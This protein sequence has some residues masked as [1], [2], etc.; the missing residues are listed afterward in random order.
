MGDVWKAR[1]TE[2][3][4]M[5][6]IKLLRTELQSNPD[7][8]ERFEREPQLIA[9]LRHP[10]IVKIHD[11]QVLPVPEEDEIITYMV[12]DFVEGQTLADYIRSTSRKGKFPPAAD[13][14]YIFSAISR[15]LDYAHDRGMIH[16]DI[17]PANILLDQRTAS[18]KPMGEP[19]LTDFGI[20]R[21][22][23]FTT[24][25]VA[26]ALLGT[27][28]YIAP[29]Q[30]KGQS[31]DKRSDLYSLGVILYEMMTG[32]TPFR[33]DTTIAIL[34]QHIHDMPT[35]PSLINPN[36]P[37]ALNMVILKSISKDPADRYQ[38][39]T[40]MTIALAD[41]LNVP[42]PKNLLPTRT[43]TYTPLSASPLTPPD[44]RMNM[45]TAN[46]HQSMMIPPAYAPT[47]S[48]TPPLPLAQTREILPAST[49]I[50]P[51]A[52]QPMPIPTPVQTPKEQQ[53]GSG[54]R[55]M[56][57]GIALG[58]ILLLIV[59]IAAAT[60][61]THK[62][63]PPTTVVSGQL[64][65]TNSGHA[66]AGTY[67]QVQIEMHNVLNPPAGHVYY[68]WIELPGMEGRTPQH[69]QV[70]VQ[71]SSISSSYTTPDHA[72][73]LPPKA[74]FLITSESDD[75]QPVVPFTD[76]A[77]RLYYATITQ[78]T[79]TFTIAPCPASDT[80]TVCLG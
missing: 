51:Q 36:I 21:S 67:D 6:A 58:L 10:N 61:T 29:E 24:R 30:A 35:P 44:G 37:P 48:N 14:V 47:T 75:Q 22:E 71:N 15:A 27:P 19:I 3:G 60:I 56:I 26:G 13:I 38:S 5:V 40:E 12:M 9:S 28:L 50:I 25:T 59:G 63:T 72:N 73:L 16:R 1:D 2:L 62:T 45:S 69:W 39:A 32:V 78:P 18:T 43:P 11:F 77:A 17:K 53:A 31:G 54:K 33:G 74:L 46:T 34:M 79:T 66:P 64:R 55:R 7:F 68:A 65:F 76:P 8:V 57:A 70:S 23:T 49:H 80:S 41:A 52:Q 42:V 4:R 20:A